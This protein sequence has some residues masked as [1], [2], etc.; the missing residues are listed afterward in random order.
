MGY[1]KDTAKTMVGMWALDKVENSV[2]MRLLERIEQGN[3]ERQLKAYYM[4]VTNNTLN[5][6][7]CPHKLSAFR[8]GDISDV[9][10]LY[11]SE[12]GYSPYYDVKKK[13][14]EICN[15]EGEDLFKVEIDC[16]LNRLTITSED[17]RSAVV[18]RKNEKLVS[19]GNY[20][21]DISISGREIGRVIYNKKE[22]KYDYLYNDWHI[23]CPK[24]IKL[25][26]K[27]ENDSPRCIRVMSDSSGEIAQIIPSPLGISFGYNVANMDLP[28]VVACFLIELRRNQYTF[29]V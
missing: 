25:F 2:P 29:R 21:F 24:G 4:L 22:M 5:K 23:V 15:L 26:S 19:N 20:I 13:E 27:E 6:I 17:G 14:F 28:V 18:K 12:S 16:P 3:Y 9:S 11:D 7:Q 1:I 10:V 8:T